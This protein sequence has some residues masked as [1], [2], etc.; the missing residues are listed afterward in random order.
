MLSTPRRRPTGALGSA[1]FVSALF[2]AACS[3]GGGDDSSASPGTPQPID[4][5]SLSGVV[6]G[7]DGQ[8]LNGALVR[9]GNLEVETDASGAFVM[10]FPEALPSSNLVIEVDGSPAEQGGQSF[11]VERF[12]FSVSA[13]DD[14]PTVP[15]PIFLPDRN[16]PDGANATLN[17]NG[18]G[19]TLG[20]VFLNPP[21]DGASL[22]IPFGTTVLI[23][24]VPATTGL[25][26]SIVPVPGE[27][28]GH[29]FPP[30]LAPSGFAAIGPTQARFIPSSGLPGL[31]VTLPNL[32]GFPN[33]ATVDIW[34]YDEGSLG[35]V[36]RS[37]QTGQQG[38]VIGGGTAISANGVV[39]EGGIYTAALIVDN[40]L[41]TTIT[42][43]I[44]DFDGSPVRDAAVSTEFGQTALSDADGVFTLSGIPAF[45]YEA[46]LTGGGSVPVN[47]R[48]RITTAA[49]DG[50]V[51]VPPITIPSIGIVPGSTTILSDTSID[52][53]EA[54]ALVGVLTGDQEVP[55]TPVTLV[56]P[57]GSMDVQVGTGN[58]FF[59]LGLEPGFYTAS[60][61]FTAS[62][63]PVYASTEVS[64]GLTSA[65]TLSPESGTGSETLIVFVGVD[66]DSSASPL[67]P[68]GGAQ[69]LL[70]GTDAGS[71]QGILR[72]T[73]PFGNAI[74]QGVDGP[75]T[76]SAEALIDAGGVQRRAAATL[77]SFTATGSPVQLAL[78]GSAPLNVDSTLSGVVSGAPPLAPNTEY[79]VV[80]VARGDVAGERFIATATVNGATGAYSLNVP[81]D[82]ILD[83]AVIQTT[84]SPNLVDSVTVSIIPDA[85]SVLPIAPGSNL[86][87]D[88]PAAG[89]EQIL[90]NQA[91]PVALTGGNSSNLTTD[92]ELDLTLPGATGPNDTVRFTLPLGELDEPTAT[93]ALP[94]ADSLVAAGYTL[95]LR[96]SEGADTFGAGQRTVATEPLL[97]TASSIDLGLDT[98]PVTLFPADG[99]QFTL[100]ELLDAGVAADLAEAADGA[101]LARLRFVGSGAE[102]ALGVDESVWTLWTAA[103]D[104]P[105][106]LPK[107]P[108]PVWAAGSTVTIELLAVRSLDG[109]ID[110]A[111]FAG[112]D[113]INALLN[114]SESEILALGSA[115]I[116]SVSVI[117][118]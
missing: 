12:A 26:V 41:S 116:V 70:T 37:V 32:G 31:D 38:T 10:G 112:D 34:A 13:D 100:S 56:G 62:G 44:V 4:L 35:W 58:Q 33:G 21:G 11:G 67:V 103:D 50:A 80:C 69:V 18:D 73:D 20:N 76:V 113:P 83:F 96:A 114:L 14:R 59:V 79:E 102:L 95:V 48:Y 9:L 109:P 108:M 39:V 72:T 111:S 53:P 110:L 23:G 16:G 92:L 98:P 86:T 3:S 91:V 99:A 101:G 61:E 27:E 107:L 90:F 28:L 46:A 82:A 84:T 30:N 36:N 22:L 60:T 66:D 117:A 7:P 65:V 81:S 55:G 64:I 93:V 19:E 97:T 105:S 45:D 52:V 94:D 43:S 85:G 42:G 47:L 87:F 49:E 115:D 5:A 71:S 25:E 29:P 89:L 24:G 68:F 8:P 15:F 106:V 54:G 17:L 77:S 63:P 2:L 6:L 57:D 88:I 104:L 1:T 40:G 51:A 78:D 74:F 75:F 118:D